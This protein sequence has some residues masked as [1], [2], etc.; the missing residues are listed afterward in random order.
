[1]ANL[2]MKDARSILQ[3]ALVDLQ[4][5]GQGS[6]ATAK[7]IQS[8][9]LPNLGMIVG[10]KNKSFYLSNAGGKNTFKPELFPGGYSGR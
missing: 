6:S 7:M 8:K 2:K 10:N 4:T 9:I 5:K 3:K 1:M